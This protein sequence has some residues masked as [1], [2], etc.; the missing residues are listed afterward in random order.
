[1][2]AM[3]LQLRNISKRYG[4]AEILPP[5]SLDIASGQFLTLLGPSGSGKTTVLRL[6]GGF[7]EPSGGSV[8]FDG[9]DITNVPANKRPFNTVFQDY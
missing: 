7:T 2:T 3:N 4:P 9:K 8:L 6:I 1:M 5:L